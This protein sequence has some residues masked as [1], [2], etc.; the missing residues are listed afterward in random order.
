MR[1]NY[2]DT[3][4][5]VAYDNDFCYMKLLY[6]LNLLR[7]GAKFFGTNKDAH[8]RVGDL[9]FPRAGCFVTAL[10]RISGVKAKILG[11]PNPD[12]L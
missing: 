5:L 10:E 12:G 9:L 7:K 1:S 4:I 6:A 2:D 8:D 11:K 3:A